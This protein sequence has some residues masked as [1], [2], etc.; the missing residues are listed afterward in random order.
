MDSSI[1]SSTKPIYRYTQIVR[2]ILGIIEV[3]LAFRFILK[4]LGANTGAGFT[5]FIY[6]VTYPLAKPFISVFNKTQIVEGSTIE[7]GTLLAI[8]V[9]W[10]LATVIIKL[11]LMGKSV[12]TPEAAAKLEQ[13]EQETTI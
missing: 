13:Q 2:Y 1:A 8:L 12:S 9:Y 10:I 5:K 3:L 4:F 11:F 6:S 7:W